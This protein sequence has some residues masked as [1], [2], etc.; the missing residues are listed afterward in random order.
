MIKIEII[1]EQDDL[2]ITYD[3]KAF[4]RNES[5]REIEVAEKIRFFLKELMPPTVSHPLKSVDYDKPI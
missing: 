5:Q 1:L 4:A 3:A 2:E